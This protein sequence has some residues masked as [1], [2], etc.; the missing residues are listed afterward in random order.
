MTFDV[1]DF[2][3]QS[4]TIILLVMMM[5]MLIEF[6]N[7]KTKGKL[8]LL[9]GKHSG[10]QIG[11]AALFGLIPGC[12]GIF[13]IVSLYTH[14]LIS[15]GT[16][17]AAAIT[18]FGDEAFFMISFIPKQTLILICILFVIA[19][20][21]GYTADLPLFKPKTRQALPSDDVFELHEQDN[22]KTATDKASTPIHGKIPLL[23]IGLIFLIALFITA[24]LTGYVGHNHSFADNF[25]LQHP[26]AV[27]TN[28]PDRSDTIHDHSPVSF[29]VEN[30]IFLLIASLT[31]ILLLMV[32]NHFFEQ[33]I[34]KHVIGKHLL[35]IVIWVFL[36]M[37][38]IKLVSFFVDINTFTYQSWGRMLLLLFAL[39][40]A[41]LPESGPNLIIL[42]LFI[43]G[44]VPFSVLLA[45]SILQEGHGGLPLIAENPTDFVRL[46]LIK[47][48][49][50]FGVGMAGW[51][52]E[53]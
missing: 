37:L 35:K 11:I 7:V 45:N 46:K 6:V 17:L 36:M 49:I 52:L 41:L 3:I 9:L 39:M 30:Y 48:I 15:F 44:V 40:I 14:R 33:H 16:L 18:S 8:L 26:T 20:I 1:G 5:M 21:A 10:L 31:L 34:R 29:S 23:R 27:L 53:F 28:A 42:F 22:C 25:S 19:L 24:I 2:F 4:M 38:F 47:G 12:V 50:A 51:W 32:N 43:D 13:A